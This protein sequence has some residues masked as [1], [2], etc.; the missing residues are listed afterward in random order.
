MQT[1]LHTFLQSAQGLDVLRHCAATIRRW[2]KRNAVSGKVIGCDDVDDLAGAI[3][4]LILEREGLRREL[5]AAAVNGNFPGL[6]GLIVQAFK[7]HVRD[8]RRSSQS[9]A[10]HA[11]YRK[12]VRLLA[13]L[14]GFVLHGGREGS[15]YGRSTIGPDH[16]DLM[17]HPAS[18]DYSAWP[19][20]RWDHKARLENNLEQAA[21]QF[22]DAAMQ[23]ANRPGL[24]AVRDMLAW[25]EAKG[26][27]DLQ[28]REAIL[29]SELSVDPP[30]FIE[31]APAALPVTPQEREILA[32]LAERIVA[33]WPLEVVR[34]FGLVHGQGFSQTEAA[35]IMG[36]ASASG[37][38]YLLRRGLLNL[39]EM[40][41]AWPELFGDEQSEAMQEGFLE[42]LLATCRKRHTG[43]EALKDDAGCP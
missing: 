11:M 30:S 27:V 24:V 31:N 36:Y 16:G 12:I 20:P 8:Q 26:V 35:K 5:E 19:D 13:R 17:T 6:H 43:E 32:N 28:S 18:H 33:A 3:M 41:A 9:S 38:N 23:S 14:E 39:R 29:E 4:L 42:C 40:I 15:W 22:W 25:L 21:E 37:I 7:L 1:A 10:W 34:A 2:M